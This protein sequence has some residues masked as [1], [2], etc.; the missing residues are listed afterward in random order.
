VTV[1]TLH[2]FVEVIAVCEFHDFLFHH[3]AKIQD[4]W[5]AVQA[6][7]RC[8]KVIRQIFWR[9]HLIPQ[10]PSDIPTIRESFATRRVTFIAGR[11]ICGM[12]F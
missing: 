2:T 8:E 10:M 3:I 1:H 9:S 7:L 5:M 12:A 11:R 4:L 6:A